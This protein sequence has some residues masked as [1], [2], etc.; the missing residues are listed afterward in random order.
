MKSGVFNEIWRYGQRLVAYDSASAAGREFM[1]FLEPMNFYSGASSVRSKAGLIP[2]EKFR[3]ISEPDELFPSGT[4]TRIVCGGSAF[5][6]LSVNEVF[7][8]ERI[9]HREC[10]LLKTGEVMADA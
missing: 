6:L 1:G 2:T 4:S 7:D 9:A 5:E 3:L 10:V 8:G